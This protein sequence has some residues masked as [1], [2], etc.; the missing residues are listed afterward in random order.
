[1]GKYQLVLGDDYGLQVFEG[2][3]GRFFLKYVWES[4]LFGND[5]QGKFGDG[6]GYFFSGR[7]EVREY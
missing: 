4:F 5:I 6:V 1:M 7:V 3:F 2:G